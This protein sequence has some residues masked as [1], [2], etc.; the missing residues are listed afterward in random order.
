MQKVLAEGVL[1]SFVELGEVLRR[2]ETAIL[3]DELDI[4]KIFFALFGMIRF[5]KTHSRVRRGAMRVVVEGEGWSRLRH[6]I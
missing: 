5:V 4:Q 1:G 2:L 3:D 6:I